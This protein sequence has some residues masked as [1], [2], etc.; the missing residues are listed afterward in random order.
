MMFTEVPEPYSH[1]RAFLLFTAVQRSPNVRT[2]PNMPLPN[3]HEYWNCSRVGS[4][5]VGIRNSS[6]T[7]CKEKNQNKL[8]IKCS[9][10]EE[11][12]CQLNI[13]DINRDI[14]DF[15][16]HE[17]AGGY[18]DCLLHKEHCYKDTKELPGHSG[19]SVDKRASSQ[20]SKNNY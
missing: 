18:L 8:K 1:D 5:S 15:A 20:N 4:S 9:R 12:Y 13:M 14:D 11:C 3:R 6:T 10:K 17:V 2:N 7:P 16:L 19:E